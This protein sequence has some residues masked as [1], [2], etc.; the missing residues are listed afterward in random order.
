MIERKEKKCKGTGKSKNYG[1]G[2]LKIIHRY[3]LCS[4]CFVD[5]LYNSEEGKKH[6]NKAKI[7]GKSK[8]EKKYKADFRAR[9]NSTNISSKNF[10]LYK[11]TAWKWCSHYVLLYY[12]DSNCIVQC[13]TDPTLSYHVTDKNIHVGHYIKYRDGNSTN[14]ST[15]LLFENLAPQSA[16]DNTKYGGK[17]EVMKE[18]LI[19]HHGEEKI[20]NLDRIKRDAYKLDKYTLFQ[21]SENYKKLFKELLDKRNIINPWNE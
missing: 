3:G 17:P 20:K 5:W 13:S 1:C 10:N 8:A 4:K 14:N 2:E 15:A 21:I 16:R 12:A 9:K 7:K 11:T 6:L 19:K 18:W